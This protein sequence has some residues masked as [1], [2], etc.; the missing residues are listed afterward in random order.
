MVPPSPLVVVVPKI[1]SRK[2]CPRVFTDKSQS[3]LFQEFFW[4]SYRNL[5]EI[6]NNSAAICSSYKILTGE[7]RVWL[8]CCVI[9]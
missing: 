8:L 5:E 1:V 6:F 2:I 7:N 4:N 3:R 9:R